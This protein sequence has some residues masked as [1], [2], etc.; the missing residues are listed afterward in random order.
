MKRSTFLT[1]DQLRVG[2]LIVVGFA[3]LGVAIFKLGESA[4]L[5]SKRYTLVAFLPA[6]NGLRQG[7]QVSIAGQLAGQIKEIQFLPLDTD[8]TKNLKIILELDKD[9]Q[10]Q[11]RKD[12]RGKIRTL[13]LLGDKV[14]DISPGTPRYAVLQDGDVITITPA[15]DYEQVIAQASG[16][17]GDV[18]VL[19]RDL[20]KV[21]S[22]IVR[23]E[24]TLG[25]L[26]T[27]RALYDQLNTT[28][29]R[30]SSLMA[31]LQNPNGTVGRL[32]NDPALYDN[33]IRTMASVDT[34]LVQINSGQG[35]AGKL[36][37][38]DSLYNHLLSV[39]ARADSLVKGLSSGN[40]T[41]SKLLTDDSLYEELMKTLNQLNGLLADVKR[42]PRRYTKGMIKVF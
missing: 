33:V 11:V 30:T 12:S 17:V 21:T 4:H 16:A 25:Q 22:G 31:R 37:K 5:F 35:T 32:L 34:L 29:V 28:L 8:T 18:V 40:S 9:L 20:R 41:A 39:T 13:G 2:V 38:D 24:G 42:D 1:W 23:G 10:T 3:I 36:L 27:N 7:G 26:V 19:T 14:F 6:A 15:L